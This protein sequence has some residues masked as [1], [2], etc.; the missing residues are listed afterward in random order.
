[1]NL[2][3]PI[4]EI[5]SASGRGSAHPFRHA[6]GLLWGVPLALVIA[7]STPSR[8]AEGID[9]AAGALSGIAEVARQGA[10]PNG[11]AA[12]SMS[13]TACNVGTEPIPYLAA[14]DEAHPVVVMQLYRESDGRFV[15]IGASDARHEYFPLAN[16]QCDACQSPGPG[17]SL[18]LG[19]STESG[20]GINADRMLL[21]PRDEIDPYTGHWECTGSHFSG[22]VDDCERR[23]GDSGHGPLDH[24][25]TA[26]DQDL[27]IAG[28]SYFYELYFLTEGDVDHS[29]N[30]GSRSCAMFWTGSHWAFSSPAEPM[31]VGPALLRWGG[32]Q[33]WATI[34]GDGTVLLSSKA[35][36]TESGY[37]Y[38]YALFNLD[39]ARRV[40][41]LSIPVGTADVSAIGFHDPDG[42]PSDDWTATLQ[43]GVLTWETD[44]ADVDPDGPGL[45]FGTLYNFWF[46][47]AT[48]PQH[49]PATLE[50]WKLTG[51]DVVFAEA[52]VPSDVSAVEGAADGSILPLSAF[53][54]PS[55]GATELGFSLPAAGPVSLRIFDAH[56]GAVRSLLDGPQ[57]AGDRRV[58]WDGRDERGRTVGGGVYFAVLRAGDRT[59]TRAITIMR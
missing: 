37:R 54:N 47:S 14:M 58:V 30:L 32:L 24:R 44:P 29:N 33:S 18:G 15:Q 55:S 59:S 52:E 8:G 7:S 23:H 56:G 31:A 46:E 9:I 22:G 19:C 21:A 4:H 5:S 51:D 16:S 25:L 28:A 6:K 45:L 12:L 20:V 17:S 38:E 13:S 49:G 10:Y 34:P 11:I 53:P 40:R 43:N 35:L 50:A 2:H 39:S 1:M 27:G 48:P 42:D 36:P 57:A 26:A 3:D 41:R